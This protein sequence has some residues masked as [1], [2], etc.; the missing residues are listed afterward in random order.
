[1][2]VRIK[3][4]IIPYT[5]WQWIEITNNHVINVLLREMNN[6][7]HVNG[8]MEL[9][10]D[11]QLP[12]G[13]RP[14]DTFPVWVTTG[15]ILQADWWQQSWIILNWK[16]T[17]WDYNRLIYANDWKLYYDSW[18]WTW[19]EI[20]GVW[21]CKVH[22]FE[23]P[24]NYDDI[25]DIVTSV[26]YDE[27]YVTVLREWER[28]TRAWYVSW[29]TFPDDWQYWHIYAI[30][31]IG[32][33]YD[34][35]WEWLKL[36]DITYQ[37]SVDWWWNSIKECTWITIST[38]PHNTTQWKYFWLVSQWD[39][40]SEMIDWLSSWW[41]IWMNTNGTSDW[42]WEM[43][44]ISKWFPNDKKIVLNSTGISWYERVII[45]NASNECVSNTLTV[46]MT[47][48]LE[49]SAPSNPSPWQIWYDATNNELKVYI[50][51]SWWKT[52]N[53]S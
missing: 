53:V 11:L 6:L 41:R 49:W 51:N 39:D 24:S 30:W 20:G 9:Y 21:D 17:S 19:N 22:I 44:Y 31:W 48:M 2:P 18:T 12:A 32:V 14:T 36:M 7:I 35:L 50:F 23:V 8:D 52:I 1:M 25:T 10:V 45:Y 38:Y 34:E 40:L 46:T 4:W 37:V 16:T 29:H 3:D 13:I 15:K 27:R 43:F 47:P 33:N 5:W 26:I 42:D 28:H